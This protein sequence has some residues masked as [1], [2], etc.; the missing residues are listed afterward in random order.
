MKKCLLVATLAL[1]AHV[2]FAQDFGVII[3]Q[4]FTLADQ[5]YI[6]YSAAAL[7]WF[8]APLGEQVDLYLSAA[9]GFEFEDGEGVSPL[10]EVNRFEL[11]YRP[12]AALNFT[13]GR[14]NF[15]DSTGFVMSGLFDGVS[16]VVNFNGGQLNP[17][18]FY[19]GLLY[20]KTASISLNIQDYIDY[21]DDDLYFASRRIAGGLNWEKT[22]IFDSQASLH[23]SGIFQFD[24][25]DTDIIVHS[26]YLAAKTAVPLTDTFNLNCGA[27]L[28][29]LEETDQDV[30][31]AFAAAVDIQQLFYGAF[32]GM[33]AAGG[34]FSSG[35]WNDNI[36]AFVPITGEA[37]GRVLRP[38]LSGIALLHAG[39]TVRLRRALY[40][41]LSAAYLFRTD[42]AAFADHDLDLDS[43]SPALGGE[44]YLGVSWSP[45]SDLM[46][47]LGG[48]LFF[49]GMG[50]S[51]VDDAKV[52]YRF[53]LTAGISL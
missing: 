39:Y 8:A 28:E 31:A 26:Q 21:Y 20:K 38:N 50:N 46:F 29:L 14:Q 42:S 45:L 10:F 36:G 40:A 12:A 48:G 18:V 51:F 23:V 32:P 25:N 52:K 17:G 22:G 4:N 27:M 19:T 43:D 33:L 13:V 11:T 37:Q 44:C 5:N 15:R 6:Y 53:E 7:P 47:T 24:L 16:A 3:N 49:P 35:A 41:E 9:G 34:R 1:A 30:R 2:A